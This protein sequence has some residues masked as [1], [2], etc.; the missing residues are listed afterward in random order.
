M[1]PAV[2]RSGQEAK[3]SPAIAIWLLT[4]AAGIWGSI[5]ACMCGHFNLLTTL[6]ILPAFLGGG[7]LF[8][9]SLRRGRADAIVSAI[10]MLV[11]LVLAGKCIIGVLWTGHHPFIRP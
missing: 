9:R 3:R 10:A 6:G 1:K 5:T 7:Y 11:M 4:V 8:S 2:L